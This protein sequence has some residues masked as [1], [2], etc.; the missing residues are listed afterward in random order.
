M[1]EK[2]M[3]SFYLEN[4]I[5]ERLKVISKHRGRSIAYLTNEA[6]AEGLKV[7]EEKLRKYN[8]NKTN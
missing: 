3:F 5:K 1:T 7:W 2:T 8:E 6:L 4:K